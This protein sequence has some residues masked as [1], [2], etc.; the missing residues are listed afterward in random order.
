MRNGTIGD[1]TQ[2]KIIE[3]LKVKKKILLD[4]HQKQQK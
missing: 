1:V 4:V 2:M 3:S